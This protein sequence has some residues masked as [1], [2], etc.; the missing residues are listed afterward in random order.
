[1]GVNASWYDN[2]KFLYAFCLV[3]ADINPISSLK[4]SI[5][6]VMSIKVW[7]LSMCWAL[8]VMRVLAMLI[9][10]KIWLRTLL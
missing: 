6:V 1:M 2:R 3:A 4:T 8:S 9:C 7:V 5:V 10:Y